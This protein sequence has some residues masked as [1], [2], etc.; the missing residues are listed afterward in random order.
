[1]IVKLVN[2]FSS[3]FGAYIV[4]FFKKKWNGDVGNHVPSH[5]CAYLIQEEIEAQMKAD[6]IKLA[7]EKLK[8]AKV[9][10]VRQANTDFLFCPLSWHPLARVEMYRIIATW[11]L[12]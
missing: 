9:K 2:W 6:K 8:E 7:L 3:L 10:K 5:P 4:L 11:T 12:L 1:M